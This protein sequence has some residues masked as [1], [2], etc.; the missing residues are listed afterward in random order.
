MDA[1][2]LFAILLGLIVGLFVG[3]ILFR[4]P[5]AEPEEFNPTVRLSIIRHR[6]KG[7]IQ[8]VVTGQAYTEPVF[9]EHPQGDVY[10]ICCSVE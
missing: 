10:E 5:Q 9:I 1:Q 2:L 4:P 7:G 8:P 6:A 3:L